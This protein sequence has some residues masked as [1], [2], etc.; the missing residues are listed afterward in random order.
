ML[1][2]YTGK[3]IIAFTV[4]DIRYEV[5]FRNPKLKDTVEL[6]RKLSEKELGLIGGLKPVEKVHEK[7]KT[8]KK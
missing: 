2:K 5:G 6:P 8:K 1:Y 3:G 4:D 7:D